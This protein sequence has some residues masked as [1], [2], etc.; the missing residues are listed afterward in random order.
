MDA[1]IGSDSTVVFDFNATNQ[2]DLLQVTGYTILDGTL[3]INILPSFVLPLNET[4]FVPIIRGSAKTGGQFQTVKTIYYN[5]IF[6]I[7]TSFPICSS[8]K[9]L[10]TAIVYVTNGVNLGLAC[11]SPTTGTTGMN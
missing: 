5:G 11:G 4:L 1:I 8:E 9:P 10:T 6:D 2:Y 3:I 7:I